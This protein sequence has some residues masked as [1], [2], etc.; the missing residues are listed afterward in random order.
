MVAAVGSERLVYVLGGTN[1]EGV[2][3]DVAQVDSSGLVG[4]IQM[5]SAL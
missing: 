3:L 4:M 2:P 5:T 1:E